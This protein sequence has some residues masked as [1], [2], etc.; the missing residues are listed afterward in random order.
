MSPYA[1]MPSGHAAFALI[2]AA[3]VFTLARPRPVRAL[4]LLYPFGVLA[5]ITATGNH[6]WL[7]AAGGAAAAAPGFALVSRLRQVAPIRVASQA[8]G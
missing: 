3:T 7:D 2:V 5:E 4:A 1:A 8:E 6:V